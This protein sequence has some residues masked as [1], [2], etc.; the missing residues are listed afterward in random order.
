LIR[1]IH[2]SG[3]RG[4]EDLRFAEG[5]SR[6][7]RERIPGAPGTYDGIDVIEFFSI[8]SNTDAEETRNPLLHSFRKERRKV[9]RPRKSSVK[10][11][12]SIGDRIRKARLTK[13]FTQTE[14]GKRVGL[15][16]GMVTYYEVR[17]VS[18]SPELL[19][20][21]ARVL[22]VTVEDLV[23]QRSRTK[24]PADTP[25]NVQ[26][27]RRVNKIQTLPPQDRKSVLRMID[28]LA[29]QAAKRKVS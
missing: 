22:A 10:Q 12:E 28:A 27:W 24:P 15:S 13:G 29:E 26:L 25:D 11:G 3:I 23:G 8:L 6:G 2:S 9:P 1:S 21:L 19:L 20:K 17:G 7:S 14:L 4:I 5:L 18:P 16:Q